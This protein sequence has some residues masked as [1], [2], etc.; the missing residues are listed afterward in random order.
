MYDLSDS[1]KLSSYT[2]FEVVNVHTAVEM[3]QETDE[4]ERWMTEE[5]NIPL[6]KLMQGETRMTFHSVTSGRIRMR[7]T[8]H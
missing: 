2:L 7:M 4:D 6:S 5:D 8:F 1:L 3:T